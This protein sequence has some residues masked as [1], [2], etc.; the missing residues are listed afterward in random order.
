MSAE[1]PASHTVIIYQYLD[2]VRTPKSQVG[3]EQNIKHGE[4][5]LMLVYP[6]SY[7]LYDNKVECSPNQNF[8]IQNTFTDL[9]D[10]ITFLIESVTDDV[11]C[12]VY[13]YQS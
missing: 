6:K 12:T 2:G 9:G 3:E 11:E 5:F 7:Y 1:V 10:Q 4:K 13:F 8:S